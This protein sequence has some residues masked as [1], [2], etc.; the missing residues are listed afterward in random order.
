MATTSP[1]DLPISTTDTHR[2]DAPVWAFHTLV[3]WITWAITWVAWFW[4]ENDLPTRGKGLIPFVA[5]C[6]VLLAA[7]I[8]LA[9]VA[10]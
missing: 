3:A 8:A 1:I 2:A 6:T 10:R 4:T 9:T 7:V 5:G